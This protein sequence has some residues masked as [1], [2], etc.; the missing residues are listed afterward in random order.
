MTTDVS[1]HRTTDT[2]LSAS[3]SSDKS[4]SVAS[5]SGESPLQHIDGLEI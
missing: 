1:T 3:M 5:S 2:L 4:F